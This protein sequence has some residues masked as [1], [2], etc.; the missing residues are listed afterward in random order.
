MY[1]TVPVSFTQSAL[2]NNGLEVGQLNALNLTNVVTLHTQQNLSYPVVTKEL[3]LANGHLKLDGL[4][5]GHNLSEE[6]AN[7][8]LVG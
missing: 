1:L 2:D 7:T 4:V 5:N 3:Y 8:L 6:Y